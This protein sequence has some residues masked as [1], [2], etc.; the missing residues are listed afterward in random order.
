MSGRPA[1]I[2]AIRALRVV[3]ARGALPY[4]VVTATRLISGELAARVMATTSSIPG[5]AS[6]MTRRAGL[7][8]APVRPRR[9]AARLSWS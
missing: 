4:V 8:D 7:N 9:L 5:S 3:R 2:S 1:S 6:M